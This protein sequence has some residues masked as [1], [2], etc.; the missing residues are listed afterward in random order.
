M[1]Y[2][3]PLILLFSL[4]GVQAQT[5]IPPIVTTGLEAYQ[6]SGANAAL[7]VWLKGSALD[8]DTTTRLNLI[9]G[10]TQIQ[11]EAA[12]G[13]VVGFEP[14]RSVTIA[15]SLHRIYILIKFERGP[16]Y[17]VFDCYKTEHGW[18]IPSLD[19]N[20]KPTAILPAQILGGQP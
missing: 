2:I 14:I 6:K 7:E 13:K 17:A 8:G 19:F 10:L 3:A 4:I 12:Y 1:K 15:P 18:I 16:I 11:I 9:R 5:D 20:A